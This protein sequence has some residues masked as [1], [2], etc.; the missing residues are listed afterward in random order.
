MLKHVR[1][2]VEFAAK[3]NIKAT[4]SPRKNTHRQLLLEKENGEKFTMIIA[5]SPSDH[6]AMA[7]NRAIIKRFARGVINEYTRK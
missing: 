1:E 3:Y 5:A 2:L 4:D 7:N 6:L